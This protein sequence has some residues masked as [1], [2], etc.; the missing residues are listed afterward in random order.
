VISA[1]KSI[2]VEVISSEIGAGRLSR[3]MKEDVWD[4]PRPAVCEP[5]VGIL[6]VVVGGIVI[7]ESQSAFRTLETSH[8][9]NILF[10]N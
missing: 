7:A 2:A 10:S 9:P 4:Y 3:L 6:S 1:T 8:P 5:F